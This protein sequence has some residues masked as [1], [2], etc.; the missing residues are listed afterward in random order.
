MYFFNSTKLRPISFSPLRH[1][2]TLYVCSLFK[3]IIM[4]FHCGGTKNSSGNLLGP[5]KQECL[6]IVAS[7]SLN[8]T[9]QGSNSF[10]LVGMG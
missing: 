6:L 8:T 2:S 4:V 3:G 9:G 5:K 10:W 1:Y 7:N